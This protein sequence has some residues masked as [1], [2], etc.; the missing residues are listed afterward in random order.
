LILPI[1]HL[2]PPAECEMLY[3]TG[4]RVTMVSFLLPGIL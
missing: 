3:W 4:G 2:I 1:R